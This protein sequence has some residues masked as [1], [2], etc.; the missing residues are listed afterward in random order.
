MYMLA[1]IS[2]GYV[3]SFFIL[4][5]IWQMGRQFSLQ[6]QS[7]FFES[8]YQSSGLA[9]FVSVAGVAFLIPYLQIQLTGLGI[10]VQVASFDR[11]SRTAAILAGVALVAAFV[12]VGGIRAVAWVS[13]VK[14]LL[15]IFAALAVALG[16]PSIYFGRIGP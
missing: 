3:G 9:A 8:R 4:H 15:M 16:A 2:R 12:F 7:D 10:I 13:V 11:V 1:Y 14:D 5:Q 6:A